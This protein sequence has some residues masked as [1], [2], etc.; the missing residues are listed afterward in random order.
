MK[1]QYFDKNSKRIEKG[2]LLLFSYPFS[3]LCLPVK[4]KDG[5][6]GIDNYGTFVPLCDTDLENAIIY[7][8]NNRL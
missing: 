5:E 8:C 7:D 3:E 1:R 6:L 2:D 4:E